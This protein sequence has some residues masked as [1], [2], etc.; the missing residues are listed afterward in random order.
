MLF[1]R[2]LKSKHQDEVSPHL[3]SAIEDAILLGD[4]QEID[5]VLTLV[6]GDEDFPVEIR[7][8]LEALRHF[9][10]HYGPGRDLEPT[11]L[12]QKQKATIMEIAWGA[13]LLDM[14]KNE[15]KIVGFQRA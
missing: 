5:D 15:G 13:E 10:A 3:A 4:V 2:W 8:A 14:L 11:E 6:D 7:Y 1:D 12:L 9:R